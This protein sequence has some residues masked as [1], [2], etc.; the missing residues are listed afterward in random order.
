MSTSSVEED[1]RSGPG[2]D[3]PGS[4]VLRPDGD[5]DSPGTDGSVLPEVPP[6]ETPTFEQVTI[7]SRPATNGTTLVLR[8]GLFELMATGENVVGA[9]HEL[10]NAIEALG[11]FHITGSLVFQGRKNKFCERCG[12]AIFFARNKN[13][14]WM[15]FE[16]TTFDV[17]ELPVS[18]RWVVANIE[19]EL[20]A[21]QIVGGKGHVHASHFYLCGSKDEPELCSDRVKA[22]W[23]K[24]Q[25]VVLAKA[26]E[27]VSGLS[28]ILL[29]LEEEETM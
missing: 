18:E 14:K 3:D 12:A 1:D 7:V 24:N 16:T 27:A 4:G 13:N 17:S 6:G 26:D 29:E 2:S 23:R 15:P 25:N 20:C 19:G 8:S 10:A 11:K 21:R 9:L 22:H 5:T 28:S